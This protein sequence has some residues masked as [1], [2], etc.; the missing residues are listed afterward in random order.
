MKL[1]LFALAVTLL[2]QLVR[3]IMVRV[4]RPQI[5]PPG[6][7]KTVFSIVQKKPG[8][9]KDITHRSRILDEDSHADR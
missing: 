6:Q 9:E 4:G 3:G 7:R 1:I 2:Y 8:W 5:E